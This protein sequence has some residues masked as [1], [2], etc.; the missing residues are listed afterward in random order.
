MVFD[1]IKDNMSLPPLANDN[2]VIWK[3]FVN[4][5]WVTKALNRTQKGPN[6]VSFLNHIVSILYQHGLTY[7]AIYHVYSV[8]K[9]YNLLIRTNNKVEENTVCGKLELKGNKKF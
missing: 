6:I 9:L 2:F 4:P 5:I 3:Q 7:G 8:S 1:Q